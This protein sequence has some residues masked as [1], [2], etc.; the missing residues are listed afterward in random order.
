DLFRPAHTLPTIRTR[1]L[2]PT[3]TAEPEKNDKRKNARLPPGL[4]IY[5]PGIERLEKLRDRDL[6]SHGLHFLTQEEKRYDP[7][8]NLLNHHQ[9]VADVGETVARKI[10]HHFGWTEEDINIIRFALGSHDMGKID[11][12][13]WKYRSSDT[14]SPEE[15]RE[16]THRH[17]IMSHWFIMNLKARVRVEDRLFLVKVGLYTRY[18]HTDPFDI[19]HRTLVAPCQLIRM[20]DYFDARQ[21]ERAYNNERPLSQWGAVKKVKELVEDWRLDPRFAPYIHVVEII[22]DA[23]SDIYGSG[24][25][26]IPS[27][28]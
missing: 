6:E 17:Q 20:I 5:T 25:V 2:M 16:Y 1:K 10:A 15:R 3:Q 7:F 24:N 21:E 18:H 8:Y 11:P 12:T 9:R 14:F 19:P 28:Y 23:I 22:R 27:S 4:M 13:N 26:G